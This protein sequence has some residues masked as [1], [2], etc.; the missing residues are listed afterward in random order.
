MPTEL[1]LKPLSARDFEP[2]GDVIEALG[3]PS[4]HI[5]SGRCGRYHD[6]ARLAFDRG[7]AGISVFDSAPCALPMPLDLLERH[8]LGS[9]AFLP[10]S[11]ASYLVVV[12]A[13]RDGI[14]VDP[15]A[16]LATS[17][18]GVNYHRGTWHAVLAPLRQQAQFA[19]V[20]RIGDDRDP[21]NCNLENCNLEEYRF[22]IPYRIVDPA[23]LAG[24]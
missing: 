4:Y 24:G 1:A 7:R 6:L 11:G 21:E 17:A 2:Y 19:V 5:N 14:P 10:L 16:F 8:P 3:A 15:Q 12:A 20:D 23:G 18:Q 9:Q 13:D 22:P